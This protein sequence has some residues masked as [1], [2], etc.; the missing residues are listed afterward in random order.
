V[1]QL[2]APADFRKVWQAGREMK[3]RILK[4]STNLGKDHLPEIEEI[5]QRLC[6]RIES[7]NE[8]SPHNGK[9][10]KIVSVT[11]DQLRL[12]ELD[13]ELIRLPSISIKKQ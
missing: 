1:R 11:G 6:L 12:H 7:V 3:K 8:E 13:K 4:Y 2:N 10:I 9:K 5:T